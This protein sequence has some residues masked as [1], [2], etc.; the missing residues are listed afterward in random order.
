MAGLFVFIGLVLIPLKHWVW[1]EHAN[2]LSIIQI[3]SAVM[4]FLTIKKS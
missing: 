1:P 4:V 2:A 3:I